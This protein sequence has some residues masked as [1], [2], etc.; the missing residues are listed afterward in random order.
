MSIIKEK[1]CI[2]RAD[3]TFV[4]YDREDKCFYILN[5]KKVPLADLSKEELAKLVALIGSAGEK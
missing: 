4:C 3:G 5:K 2:K 1:D